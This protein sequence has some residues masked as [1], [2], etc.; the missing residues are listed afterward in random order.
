MKDIIGLLLVGP[1]LIFL[2]IVW[3]YQL[4]DSAMEIDWWRFSFVFTL[5]LAVIE[6]VFIGI[7]IV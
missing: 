5:G 3:I 2:I 7:F 1:F 6:A 4:Y